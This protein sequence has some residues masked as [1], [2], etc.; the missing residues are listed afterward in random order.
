MGDLQPQSL[1]AV[2]PLFCWRVRLGISRYG[3]TAKAAL[4]VSKESR[5]HEAGACTQCNIKDV[6][7]VVAWEFNTADGFAAAAA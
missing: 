7:W 4:A 6:V 5:L 2:E 3:L 1:P